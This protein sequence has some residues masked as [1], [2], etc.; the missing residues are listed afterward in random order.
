MSVRQVIVEADGG[1]RG[2][3]GPAG[4]GALVRDLGTGEVLA[5]RQGYLGVRTNNVAEYQALIAGL[6]AAAELGAREVTVRM[7]SKLVVE[8]MSGRWQVKHPSMRPLA[9][10]AAELARSFERISFAWIPRTQNVAADRL[11]NQAMDAGDGLPDLAAGLPEPADGLAA[12]MPRLEFEQ[13][14]PA[15]PRR[16][17]PPRAPRAANNNAAWVPGSVPPTRLVLL[18]HGV[19]DYSVAGRFAG[20]SDLDLTAA[21]VAQARQAADRIAQFGELVAIYS[22]PLLRT[23]H[24]AELVADRLDLPVTVEDGLIETDF[25]DWDGYT[26]EEVRRKWPDELGHWLADPTVPPPAGESLAI[27]SNRVARAAERIRQAQPG[28]S[29]VLVSHVWPIKALVQLAL[30]AP[31]ASVHRMYLAAAAISVIDYLP[32]EVVSLRSFNETGHLTE[33]L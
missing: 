2:N 13:P 29:V 20:R 4:Y 3:P 6:T 8:Q 15:A 5:E 7:D 12:P 17:E 1:S 25:G 9:A 32:D 26:F 33:R 22:S 21:G 23:R 27:T 30:G 28:R 16:S 14:E 24:T 19:T 11:A 10:R 18:R 31:A